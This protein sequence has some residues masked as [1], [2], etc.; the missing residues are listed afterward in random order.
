MAVFV[1][2]ARLRGA[3]ERLAGSRATQ[4]LVDFLILKR[5]MQ[6]GGTDS[7]R[8]STRDEIFTQSIGDLMKCAPPD[9]SDW[10]GQPLINVFGT[11]R[12]GDKGYRSQKYYSNGTAV[13]VPRWGMMEIV[14]EGPR[15]VRLQATYENGLED[16]L[17]VGSGGP[18]PRLLDAAV[19][20]FRFHDLEDRFGSTPT[21]EQIVRGF[22]QDLGLTDAEVQALFESHDQVPT[23]A[24]TVDR[25]EDVSKAIE[26]IRKGLAETREWAA[27]AAFASPEDRAQASR[28]GVEF[29][30]RDDYIAVIDRAEREIDRFERGEIRGS[31]L[32]GSRESVGQV[33]YYRAR[34]AVS[35]VKV[36]G[37]DV[38]GK[39]GVFKGKDGE[40][41]VRWEPGPRSAGVFSSQVS[42]LR[43]A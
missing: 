43:D 27:N 11:G 39:A 7:V 23:P 40:R 16:F 1:S 42:N 8:L 30:T 33:L 3:V 25:S 34:S 29:F 19:W 22:V 18:K 2:A 28:S 41:G 4:R 13:T 21:E 32:A 17:L 26:A 37:V 38:G 14:S 9:R 5:A 15:I 24:P 35:G 6:S 36:G 31:E 10:Q 20:Y 12:H